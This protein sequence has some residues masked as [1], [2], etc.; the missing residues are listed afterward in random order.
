MY[1]IRVHINNENEYIDNRVFVD[2]ELPAVPRKGEFLYLGD[3]LSKLEEKA[4]EDLTIAK[5]YSP[6]WFYGASSACQEP[7]QENLKD[8]SF[9]DAIQVSSVAYISGEDIVHVEIDG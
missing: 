4:K 2:I 5:D 8:L 3:N 7:K 1:K 6:K 9:A